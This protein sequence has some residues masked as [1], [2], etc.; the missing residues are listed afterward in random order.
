MGNQKVQSLVL[1]FG[2]YRSSLLLCIIL[3]AFTGHGIIYSCDSVP[4]LIFVTV[5]TYGMS[6]LS[7]SIFSW[8]SEYFY[9]CVKKQLGTKHKGLSNRDFVKC[10]EV[11]FTTKRRSLKKRV[12][13]LLQKFFFSIKLQE[14]SQIHLT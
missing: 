14:L 2:V 13:Q 10:A 6:Y 5:V 7:E 4:L 12:I 9:I 1:V 8:K 11:G 3:V